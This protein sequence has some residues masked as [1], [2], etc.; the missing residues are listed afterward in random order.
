MVTPLRYNFTKARLLKE[1]LPERGHRD[2]WDDEV[3]GLL[4]RLTKGGGVFYLCKWAVGAQRWLRIG[5]FPATSVKD[6]RDRA[7]ELLSDI[8]K[9]GRPWDE[10]KALRSEETLADLWR[11]FE[12]EYAIKQKRASSLA[13]DRS[14]WRGMLEPWGG[15]R[16]LS[17]ITRE[18]VKRLVEKKAESAPVRANRVAA[19]LSTMFNWAIREKGWKGANPAKGI[20]RNKEHSRD[21]FMRPGELRAMFLSLSHE[22]ESWALYFR[23]SVLCGARR[24]NMLAMRWADLDLDR[25]L[26]RVPGEE[27]KNGQPLH[28]IMVPDLVAGLRNWRDRCPSPIFV[29]PSTESKVGHKVE[30]HPAWKRVLTRAECFRLIGLLGEIHKWPQPEIDAER[31]RVLEEIGRLRLRALG[32]RQKVEGDPLG[33]VLA[34]LRD[35]VKADGG[36]PLGGGMLDVRLHDLRRTLGSWAAM[37]GATTGIIGKALGHKSTQATAIYARL[38]LDPVRAAITTATA[39]IIAHGEAVLSK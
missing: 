35:R 8:N 29:F 36:D 38:D 37:T 16:S 14:I 5:S 39:A 6:A 13:A 23:V 10:R 25:G 30:P 27:S 28:I 17:G 9:G 33:A 31:D 15:K 4:Y 7:V 24:G 18:E 19:L 32:R 21:R 12:V 11:M 3:A 22:E 20:K 2:V 34:I 1:A 26:W